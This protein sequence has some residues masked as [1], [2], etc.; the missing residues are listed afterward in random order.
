MLAKDTGKSD[1]IKFVNDMTE[2]MLMAE[3]DTNAPS[4]P[5]I[6]KLNMLDCMHGGLYSSGLSEKEACQVLKEIFDAVQG[7]P[8]PAKSISASR[9]GLAWTEGENR[10][11][12]KGLYLHELK[13]L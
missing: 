8:L 9:L 7:R 6:N 12:C 10:R 1:L 13:H 3:T 5:S 4:A 11:F 2:D